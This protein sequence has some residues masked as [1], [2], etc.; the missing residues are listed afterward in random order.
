MGFHLNSSQG[1][2]PFAGSTACG[3]SR[4]VQNATATLRN[5]LG[6]PTSSKARRAVSSAAPITSRDGGPLKWYSAGWPLSG[7]SRRSSSAAL[8]AMRISGPWRSSW[9]EQRSK[10]LNPRRR[11]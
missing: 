9:A 7:C 1:M 3:D 5:F 6:P 2:P 10:R 4:R 11:K 8:M